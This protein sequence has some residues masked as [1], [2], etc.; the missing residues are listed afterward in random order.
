MNFNKENIYNERI[1][2]KVSEL[3]QICNEERMPCFIAVCTENSKKET[4][5]KKE[6][7]T[8]AIYGME[9]TDDIIPKLVNVTLGFDTV[10]PQEI[11]EIEYN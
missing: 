1:A 4:V 9:L 5:Y 2:E 3:I 7:L 6:A 10:S 8:A 11:E